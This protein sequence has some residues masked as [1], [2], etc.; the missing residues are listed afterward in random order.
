MAELNLDIKVRLT[1]GMARWGIIVAVVFS[2]APELGS[3]SVTLTTYYPAPSGVYAQMITTAG[4]TLSRDV[5]TGVTI[6]KAGVLAP[7]RVFGAATVDGM[8]R[9]ANLE[10]T[11]G[12]AINSGNSKAADIVI[13]SDS[14]TRHDSSIMM[15]SAASA[16]R[17]FSSN[18]VFYINTW[19]QPAG[20]YNVAL[21]AAV[22]QKSTFNGPVDVDGAVVSRQLACW[23]YEYQYS[24]PAGGTQN[25]ICP[26]GYVTLT[27]GF[28]ARQTILQ[29]I[30]PPSAGVFPNPTVSARCCPCPVGGCP[31]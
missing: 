1:P 18:D 9:L 24:I 2:C 16:L 14:G 27:D 10:T 21:A 6:G 8:G 26:G 25:N 29:V 17:I 23:S 7:L 22:G 12:N 3:E 15:W 28:M 30:P 4:T 11:G 31:L 5:A 20:T 19:N 13:G